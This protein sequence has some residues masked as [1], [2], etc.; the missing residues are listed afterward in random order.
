MASLSQAK[1]LGGVGSLLVIL[2]GVPSVGP[3]LGIVGFILVLFAIKNISDTVG[4]ASIFT[5][6]IISVVL[7]IVGIVV[8]AVVLVAAFFSFAGLGAFTKGFP[9]VFQSAVTPGAALTGDIIGLILGVIL[10]L[11][12]LWV[13]L[14][15]SAFFLRKSYN[16]IAT[17][18]GVNMFHTAALLFFIGAILTIIIVGFVLIFVAGILQLVAFFSIPDQ[19]PGSTSTPT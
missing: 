15:A 4:D 16:R 6:A 14:S 10:G 8:A 3:V 2:S 11:G 12:V 19:L 7:A 17:K 1:N 5:N 18:L 13:V 9:Q